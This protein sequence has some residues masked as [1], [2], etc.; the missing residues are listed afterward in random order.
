[1]VYKN[2][3]R[4]SQYPLVSI[5]IP[6]FNG[7]N[8]LKESIESILNQNYPNL[9]I[10]IADNCSNDH[11]EE[12]CKSYL[13]KDKRVRYY[14]Q[15]AN[16]GAGPNFNFV[17]KQSKGKYFKWAAHDDICG[18]NYISTCVAK[19]ENDSKIVLCYSSIVDINENGKLLNILNRKK[20][21]SSNTLKRF[22]ELIG[23]DYN[24]EEIFGL[25]RTCVL[26]K[27][28]LIRNYTDSDRTLLTELGLRGKFYKA[29][30]IFLYHRIHSGMSTKTHKQWSERAKWFDPNLEKKVIL[31]GWIQIFDYIKAINDVPLKFR[32]KICCYFVIIKRIKW[33]HKILVRELLWGSRK[34]IKTLF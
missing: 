25:I 16:I 17:F 5:G 14:R 9:E 30:N 29:S 33:R 19:L 2:K 3:I 27:T 21:T 11:T 7:E 13:D 10:I 4:Q 18:D 31:S 22:K 15:K 32:D 26:R 34:K 6:V 20:G 28:K 12:I 8:Y 24:C 23:W 1:M